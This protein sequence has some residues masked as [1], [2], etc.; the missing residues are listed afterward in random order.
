MRVPL[1]VSGGRSS[2][3]EKVLGRAG[4]A[5]CLDYIIY[6]YFGYWFYRGCMG[7]VRTPHQPA[8]IQESLCRMGVRVRSF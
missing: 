1:K 8:V 2:L 7:M 6:S 3:P 5:R 4:S